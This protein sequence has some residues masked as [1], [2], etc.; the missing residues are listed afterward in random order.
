MEIDPDVSM[1][2]LGKLHTNMTTERFL[3]T[4]KKLIAVSRGEA[5]SD[6]RDAMPYQMLHGPEDIIPERIARTRSTLNKLLWKASMKENIGG[7]FSNALDDY[8]RTPE[9]GNVG[10]DSRIAGN[11]VKGDNGIMYTQVRGHHLLG[12]ASHMIGLTAFDIASGGGPLEVAVE[13]DAVGR[14]EVDAL[15]LAAQSLAP[16]QAGHDLQGVAED[17]AVAPVLVVL[18]ELGLVRAIPTEDQD[19]DCGARRQCE[20]DLPGPASRR[21]GTRW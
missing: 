19:R 5:E 20:S 17:H 7:Q 1:R 6:D 13:L 2:T 18:V 11:A 10:L 4:T 8:L 21:I 3:N 15:H 9:S 16:G 12:L 14:V